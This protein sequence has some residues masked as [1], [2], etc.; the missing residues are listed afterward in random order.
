[1]FS[2]AKNFLSESTEGHIG[3]LFQISS[4]SPVRVCEQNLKVSRANPACAWAVFH[5]VETLSKTAVY[6]SSPSEVMFSSFSLRKFSLLILSYV[7]Q[8]GLVFKGRHEI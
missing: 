7:G 1:M 5:G 8:V 4:R 6:F 2:G 3:F